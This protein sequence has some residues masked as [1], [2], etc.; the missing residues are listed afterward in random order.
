MKKWIFAFIIF[1]FISSACN[2]K[3]EIKKIQF[4]GEAQGTY[5]IVTYYDQQERNLQAKVDSILKDFDLS[6]SLWVPN[7]TLSRINRNE[8]TFLDSYFIDNFNLSQKIAKETNGALDCTLGP[9]IEAWGFGFKQKIKLTQQKV[10][11]LKNIIGLDKVK[12]KNNK[13]VKTDER[14][15]LNFNAIAQGY[16]VDLVGKLLRSYGIENFI[17][18]I[19]GEILANGIKPDKQNWIVGIQKPTET[20]DGAIEAQ[21]RIPLNNKAFVTSGSYRKYY[22]ENGKRYSHMI[23]P[24]TGYPVTHSLLSV[25]VLANTCAEADGYSTAF[26]IMGLEKAKEFL[27]NRNDLEAYFIFADETGKLKT[28]STEGINKLLLDH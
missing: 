5:Y 25:S 10:D 12:I 11:S 15:Q 20:S 3:Q 22:E 6:L 19:G 1:G 26:M 17:I 21:E 14:I 23:D 2:Q 16:S 13:L 9:L 27:K 28:Y 4:Q 18:D 24:V 7:S 8:A